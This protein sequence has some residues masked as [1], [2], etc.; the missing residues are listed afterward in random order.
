MIQTDFELPQAFYPS[1]ILRALISKTN[2]SEL[3]GD[4]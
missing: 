1:Y 2:R 4:S 3:N